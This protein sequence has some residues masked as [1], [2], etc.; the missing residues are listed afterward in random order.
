MRDEPPKD[1]DSGGECFA[2]AVARTDGDGGV[3]EQCVKDVLLFLPRLDAQNVL[4]ES[5]GV[6]AEPALIGLGIGYGWNWFSCGDGSERVFGFWFLR[7]LFGNEEV[8]VF[9]GRV[10]MSASRGFSPRP[11]VVAILIW[12]FH[13]LF[14]A[15]CPRRTVVD[16]IKRPCTIQ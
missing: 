11:A 1:G 16:V 3:C 15:S 12:R 10:Y 13:V 4:S 5:D 7:W 6:P 8:R 9:S 2:G 14:R